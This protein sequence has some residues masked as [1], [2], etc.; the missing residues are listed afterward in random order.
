MIIVICVSAL[1]A[2][3]CCGFA[4]RSGQLVEVNQIPPDNNKICIE[5]FELYKDKE[6][7]ELL[8]ESEEIME[9][10]RKKFDKNLERVRQEV[11]PK[12]TEQGLELVTCKNHPKPYIERDKAKQSKTAELED[13]SMHIKLRGAYSANLTLTIYIKVE[14][15]YKNKLLFYFT[16][17]ASAGL[18]VLISREK[19]TKA[20]NELG[21]DLAKTLADKITDQ[22]NKEKEKNENQK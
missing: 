4:I 1:T 6:F 14:L 18:D 22:R 10:L 19:R 7:K 16:K 20:L 12:L 3:V 5:C 11:E 2:T 21:R 15:Y 17:E 8:P 13:E 9:K